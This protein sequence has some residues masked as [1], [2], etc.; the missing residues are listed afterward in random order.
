MGVVDAGA[1][2]AALTGLTV[3]VPPTTKVHSLS[4]VAYYRLRDLL[5]TLELPPGAV[6]DERELMERLQLG[7][8]PVREAVRR[9]AGEGLVSVF[10]RRGTV[11]AAVDVR[12]LTH[13]S[14]VRTDLEALGARLAAQ[15]ADAADR[16]RARELLDQIESAPASAP[17]VTPSPEAIRAL[18]R[19]DQRVHHCVHL[20]THNRYLQET[21]G[22]YLTL[23]LRLWFLGLERVR[24]LDEA[25]G[26]H[27][28]VLTAVLDG[29]GE[30]AEHAARSHVSGFWQE[31]RRVLT[32]WDGALTD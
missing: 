23:S 29:D 25:V 12:D 13:V 10:A 20:A 16:S 21:L 28:D 15:R 7:R 9:L 6:L 32:D 17:S 4:A 14:E 18:I 11:V 1:H 22:E 30:A 19:L 2:G 26:E 3:L 31:M 5:V 24:R 8:T 27:R